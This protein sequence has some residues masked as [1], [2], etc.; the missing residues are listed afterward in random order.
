MLLSPLGERLGE[1]VAQEIAFGLTPSPSLS[2]KGERNMSGGAA[3]FVGQDRVSHQ[4]IDLAGPPPA[5]EHAVMADAGLHVVFLAIGPEAGAE[6]VRRHG[7]AD[8]A[9][10]VALALDGEQRGAADRLGVDVT[11]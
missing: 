9:N 3:L 1:G 10:V 11:T 2:P 4:G 5:A 6:I 7:L 8:G